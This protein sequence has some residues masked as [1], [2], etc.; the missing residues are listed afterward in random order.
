MFQC[1]ARKPENSKKWMIDERVRTYHDIEFRW[2]FLAKSHVQKPTAAAEAKFSCLVCVLSGD[3]SSIFEGH[4]QLLDHIRDHKGA[5]LGATVLEGPLTFSN[6][7]VKVDPAGF[8]IKFSSTTNV[9]MPNWTPAPA[10]IPLAAAATRQSH[11][12]D[13]LVD[14]WAD[15]R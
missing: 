2:L 9:V 3:T 11:W 6:E 8:D 10:N 1:V 7:G 4:T 12:S 14:P 13:D 5:Q 15:L